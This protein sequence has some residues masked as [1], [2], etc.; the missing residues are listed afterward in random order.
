MGMS[1]QLIEGNCAW[2]FTLRGELA[3]SLTSAGPVV[4]CQSRMTDALGAELFK[5]RRL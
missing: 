3:L 5:G 4:P 2:S 1:V